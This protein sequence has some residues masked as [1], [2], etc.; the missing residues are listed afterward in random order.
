MAIAQKQTCVY[1]IFGLLLLTITLTTNG[2]YAN[3]FILIV[4]EVS[5]DSLA[6]ILMAVTVHY[7][8]TFLKKKAKIYAETWYPYTSFHPVKSPYGEPEAYS[9]SAN[10]LFRHV[11]VI[12]NL[13]HS[14]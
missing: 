11:S 3:F 2:L 14:I 1:N 13:T 6:S 9:V 4:T 8:C 12:H 5:E 10:G 7:S